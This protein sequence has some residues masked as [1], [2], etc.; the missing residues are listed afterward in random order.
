MPPVSPRLRYLHSGHGF[1]C[2]RAPQV[3]FKL[4]IRR[5]D[6]L[7]DKPAQVLLNRGIVHLSK[8]LVDADVPQLGAQKGKAYGRTV[9]QCLQM[10][11]PLAG[12]RMVRD[13]PPEAGGEPQLDRG[14]RY[15][16]FA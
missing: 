6:D 11:E 12:R 5:R 13:I 10:G 4:R 15:R 14:T 8:L 3:W 2:Q 1:S 16:D 9:I 7:T